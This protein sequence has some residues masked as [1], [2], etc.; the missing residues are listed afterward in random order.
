[1]KDTQ[2]TNHD[3]MQMMF[4]VSKRAGMNYMKQLGH[5]YKPWLRKDKAGRND[6][7]S[8]GSS[9]KVKN[10]CGVKTEYDIKN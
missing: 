7:C 8:C 5:S 1:M 9:L 6:I 2:P 10:C 4:K 3:I